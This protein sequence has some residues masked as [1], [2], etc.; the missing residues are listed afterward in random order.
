MKK[1]TNVLLVAVLVS[2]NQQKNETSN[3]SKENISV[4]ETPISSTVEQISGSW[5]SKAYMENIQKTKSIYPHRNAAIPLFITLDKNELLKG[6]ANLRGFTA[7]EGGFDAPI[8]FDESKKE[9]LANGK[10]TDP[11]L[12]DFLGLKLGGQNLEMVYQNKTETYQKFDG[13]VQKDLRKILF[14]GNYSEKGSS[15]TITFSNDDKVNF[16]DYTKY[17]I[18]YDFAD[19]TQNFDGILLEKNS[20]KDLYQFKITGNTIELQKMKESEEGFKP[21]GEKYILTKK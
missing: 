1:L 11:N 12:K 2:C 16:K 13:D 9:F 4:S 7:H 18:V 21:E 6:E 17:E 8:K 14:D 10:S 5:I 20:V 3:S 19:G 15:S